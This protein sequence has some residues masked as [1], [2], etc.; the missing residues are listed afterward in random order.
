MTVVDRR[1]RLE[2]VI[3]ANRVVLPVKAPGEILIAPWGL[4]E[5]LKGDFQMDA[6]SATAV[7]AAFEAHGVFLPIDKEHHT[8]GGEYSAPDGSAVAVGWINSIHAV[9]GKGLFA[10]VEWTEEGAELIASKKYR[11]LSPVILVRRADNRAV[12]LHSI[13]LTN[14]PAFV[15]AVPIVN[16]EP[17]ISDDIW[18]RITY[19][20]N[21]PLTSTKEAIMTDLE[22]LLSQLR[23]I[24]GVDEGTDA[25]GVVAALKAGVAGGDTLRSAVCKALGLDTAKAGKDDEIVAAI[26][27]VKAGAAKPTEPDPTKFVPM[28][29][30][31]GVV[32]RLTALETEVLA[33]K[34]EGFISDGLDAGKITEAS[35][36]MWERVF[37]LD[38]DQAKKDLEAAPAMAPKS[39]RVLSRG[40][41][42]APAGPT[43]GGD[44]V[45]AH[46][47]QFDP[48][49][50]DRY[51]RIKAHMKEHKVG[52]AQAMEAVA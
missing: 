13:A 39:G 26:N 43:A 22:R 35:R 7:I 18:D 42:A 51:E 40:A 14:K 50:I 2:R 21:L 10:Q 48:N 5:S 37:K 3:V 38:P 8:V 32:D 27:A 29:D 11:Y 31:K 47:D 4:V 15:G 33:N 23:E 17:S 20:L 9:Q 24:S 41:G 34:T 19:L 44:A 30:H 36:G 1:S 52:Y 28:L 45:I 25:A 49:K 16:Q 6:E 46:R 12:E